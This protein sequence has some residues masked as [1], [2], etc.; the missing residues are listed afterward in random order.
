MRENTP[1][2]DQEYDFPDNEL[3]MST[4]D[5]RG[6][7]LHCNDAFQRVSGYSTEELIGQPHN[8]LR[9]PDMPPEAFKDMWSTIGHGRNWQGMVKNRRKDG[10]YYWV[11]ASV[12]PLMQNGRKPIGYVSVRC[13][14]T[15]NQIKKAE[16]LYTLIREQRKTG[17]P[18]IRLHGGHVRYNGWRDMLGILERA[19][20]THRM[21]GM[22]LPVIGAALLFP[23]MGWT[24]WWQLL[25]QLLLVLAIIGTALWRMDRNITRPMSI[26]LSASKHL[27]CCNLD[28]PVPTLQGRHPMALL[29]DALYQ[30][31]LTLR[32]VVLD[33]RAE[34]AKLSAISENISNVSTNL[35]GHTTH[36]VQSLH[37]CAT[38]MGGLAQ[39][40]SQTQDIL[41]GI[42]RQTQESMERA[43][44]GGQAMRQVGTLVEN[45][46]TS[47]RQMEH[48]ISTIE[49]IA[50]QTNL[51][52]LNA[53]VEA[54][55]AGEQG[56]GFAVVASEVRALA[57][58]SAQAAR[59]I[60]Q[61]ITSTSTQMSEGGEQMQ[62]AG[63]VIAQVVQAVEQVN[64]L[65][66]SMAAVAHQQTGGISDANEA[67]T[68]LD[69]VT[70][71]NAQL[72]QDSAQAA[73][74]MHDETT[75]LWRTLQVFRT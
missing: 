66:A 53:A 27:S 14:P 47:A 54:A 52:A 37:H 26:A 42:L 63:T 33:T 18:S 24:H 75:V 57:Q 36:Q 15:R 56:R 12:T 50:F 13:K 22:L 25:L 21:T 64:A 3:L 71:D 46:R 40:V 70:Q 48:I 1:V 67:L 2:F 16:A 10:T 7:I 31:R 5:N 58:H 9:H 61:L 4:T 32:S 28:D 49:T 6:Y 19:N 39:T 69:A 43:D 55:K 23:L 68:E 72:A 59:E 44:Q 35:S 34:I 17:H 11:M 29:I 73:N 65:M 60:G 74:D 51:L 20:F 41:Q 45:M 8:I 62:E 38:V 30:T